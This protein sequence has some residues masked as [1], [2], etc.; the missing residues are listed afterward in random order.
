MEV[1]S[2]YKSK[3]IDFGC[4]VFFLWN[5][6]E[7][8]FNYLV[9]S[10]PSLGEGAV[11]LFKRNKICFVMAVIITFYARTGPNE[12]RILIIHNATKNVNI[13]KINCTKKAP[14]TG[15]FCLICKRRVKRLTKQLQDSLRCL[16]SLRQHGDGGLLQNVGLGKAHH[17]CSHVGV[18]DAAVGCAKVF[19]CNLQ[20]V[21]GEF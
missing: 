14:E 3:A 18:A 7:S 15:A 1:V 21:D 9:K 10:E 4:M 12:N 8:W 17:F 6:S 13:A 11:L 16:V 5:V 19:G 20:V 2:P